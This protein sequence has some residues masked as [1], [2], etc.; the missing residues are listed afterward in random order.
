MAERLDYVKLAPRRVLD[1][2]CGVAP[3]ETMLRRR[4]PQAEL[5]ALDFALPRLRAARAGRS[6]IERLGA[7][8]A[9]PRWHPI[10]ADIARL[11][12]AA[13]AIDLVWSN[14]ALAYAD[15]GAATLR[16]WFRVLAP[17]GL[18]MF[19]SY[20]PDTLGELRAAFAGSAAHDSDAYNHVHQFDDLHDLGDVLVA[21]GFADPV[22]DMEVVTLTY[23]DVAALARDLRASGQTNARADRRRGLMSPRAWAR[24][25]AAYERVR[26]G[27]R[28]PASFEIVYGHAWKPQ[29]RRLEDGRAVVRFDPRARAA[30]ALNGR[31]SRASPRTAKPMRR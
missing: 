4:Y 17:G 12:L 18:L 28:I 7:M 11:P 26:S 8:F 10:C 19:A 5:L 9:R 1:A 21:C 23:A 20:G 2:G 30:P 24:M 29:R 3:P 31:A 25:T 14:L 15:D 6:L 16:E 22:I 13:G 27:G